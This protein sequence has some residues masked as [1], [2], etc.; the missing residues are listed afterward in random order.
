MSPGARWPLQ[1]FRI[2]S[3]VVPAALA[4]DTAFS[5][6][7]PTLLTSAVTRALVPLWVATAAALASRS[8]GALARRRGDA[9]EGASLLDRIDVL[10]ASGSAVAWTSAVAIWASVKVG[11]ASLAVVGMMGMALYHLAVI[12]TCVAAGGADP[13]RRASLSRR[14]V[15]ETAV[16]GDPVVEELRLSGVRIPIGF[17]LFAA[18][19][20][21]PRWPLSRYVVGDGAAGGEIVMERDVGPARR[22]EHE[23]EPLEVWLQDVLGL[24]R[25]V[26]VRA[27]AARLTVLPAVPSVEGA[28]TLLGAGGHDREPR[29]AVRAPTEGSLGLRAYA[30]GDDARRIHWIRSL[31]SP[32]LVV[33]LPDELPPDRPRVRLV[34]D[35]FLPRGEALA[36]NAPA[37]LL[38]ALV[39]VW[40]GVGRALAEAGVH[41]TLVTAAFEDGEVVRIRRPLAPRALDQGLRLGA[42]VRWQEAILVEKLLEEGAGPQARAPAPSIVVSYRLQPE[43]HGQPASPWIVVPALV[44]TRFDEPAQAAASVVFPHPFGSADNRWSRRR[45]DRLRRQRALRD[46]TTFTRLSA[47]VAPPR[48]GAFVARRVEAAAGAADGEGAPHVRLEELR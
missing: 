20:V 13:W 46:H 42:R 21:G 48:E 43:T 36:T 30:P 18:G 29:P 4:W 34:L 15:P 11:W 38:D 23:A 41:V 3:L 12:W 24:C 44:W 31:A 7:H 17:R 39:G 14:F 26:R 35:T 47:A 27:G 1:V 16:E 28:R 22:G 25:S 2:A 33:R 8:V 40:L 37:A 45:R 5:A 9:A 32:D 6:P 10:T 19:R